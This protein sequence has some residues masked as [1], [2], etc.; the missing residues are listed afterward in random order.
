MFK[1]KD[2]ERKETIA[3]I[4]ASKMADWEKKLAIK[5]VNSPT[6]GWL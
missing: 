5:A 4:K 6:F 3:K 2:K 1:Q